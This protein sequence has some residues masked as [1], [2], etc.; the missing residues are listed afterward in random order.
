VNCVHTW[1]TAVDDA[2]ELFIAAGIAEKSRVDGHGTA[3]LAGTGAVQR[4]MNVDVAVAGER[5]VALA[6]DVGVVTA[7]ASAVEYD[8]LVRQTDDLENRVEADELFEAAVRCPR[9]RPHCFCACTRVSGSQCI[10]EGEE[11]EAFEHARKRESQ[12]VVP[13][14]SGNHTRT[15]SCK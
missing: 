9:Q 15:S 10:L 2:Q 7:V 13:G 6:G 4:E 12:C 14:F 1:N 11:E 3:R 8:Q 5:D